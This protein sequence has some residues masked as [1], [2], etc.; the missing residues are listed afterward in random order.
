MQ[1]TIHHGRHSFCSHALGGGR[2]LAEVRDAAG[3]A[4]VATTSI[5]THVGVEDDD[6]PGDLF[7]FQDRGEQGE[8]D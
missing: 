7:D 5:Y 6:G 1:I 2:T 4:N 3:H 8:S